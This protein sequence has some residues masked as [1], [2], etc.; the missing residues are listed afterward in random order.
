MNTVAILAGGKATRLHPLTLEKPKSLVPI[1]GRAFIELQLELL[2]K[3]GVSQVILCLGHFQNLLVDYINQEQHS[4]LKDLDIQFSLEEQALGTGGAILNAID[5]LGDD[6]GVLYGDSYLP[7][8]YE[9]VFEEFRKSDKK[10]VMTVYRNDDRFDKSNV[11]FDGYEVVRYS[12]NEQTPEMQ[13]IDYGFLIFR[14]EVFT[15]ERFPIKFDLSL[16]IEKLISD[17]EMLGF[18]VENRFYEVGSFQGIQDLEAYL[19]GNE[20]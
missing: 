4:P 16:V 1:Q 7:I 17:G 9:Q 3:N 13:F 12:K 10:A 15:E 2:A 5:L 11:E 8:D 14:R 19:G 20:K 18:E 6:F